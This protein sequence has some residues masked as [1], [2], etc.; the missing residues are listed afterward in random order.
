MENVL[1]SNVKVKC[2]QQ[3]NVTG[4]NGTL[5]VLFGRLMLKLALFAD[6][7][8]SLLIHYVSNQETLF[9]PELM[10]INKFIGMIAWRFKVR[11]QSWLRK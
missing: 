7:A 8:E 9:V 10:L 4:E 3:E 1:V 2:K 6:H 11:D 5:L